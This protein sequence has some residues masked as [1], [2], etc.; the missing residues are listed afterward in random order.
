[1]SNPDLSQVLASIDERLSNVEKAISTLTTIEPALV[2]FDK[3]LVF[4]QGIVERLDPRLLSLEAVASTLSDR[5]TNETHSLRQGQDSL[6]QAQDSIRA[7]FEI[8]RQTVSTNFNT[9]QPNTNP[10]KPK[11]PT[12][13]LFSGKREDWKTFSSHLTLFFSANK[14]QYPTDHDKIQFAI[15]RLGEGS[16]FKYMQQFIPD[17]DKAEALRP[18]IITNYGSF[19]K[20]MS[21]NFGVQNAHIVAEAQLRSL[22]QKGSAMDYTNRFVELASDTDWNDSAKI[23]QYRVG[24]KDPVQDMIA[25]TPT[26]PKDFASFS[27]LAIDIDKR[28]YA[29]HMEKQHTAS[30][31]RSTS[32]TTSPTSRNST[33]FSRPAPVTAPSQTYPIAH[34]PSAP[35]AMDLSQAR[36]LTLEEKQHRKNTNACFYC[37]DATHWTSKCPA[38]KNILAS[39]TEDY[40]NNGS[41]ITFELG[42][43]SA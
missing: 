7:D 41:T 1:M 27:A 30:A 33:T 26:E 19:I 40:T 9:A 39:A 11:V 10:S 5:I 21:E 17:F 38:K 34:P 4:F 16:A 28:Q 36:H 37:G 6:R 31:G 42:K 43:D 3:H 12:P 29:R 15:S 24:L 14:A 20:I 8:L 2:F 32:S 22:K 35:M 13:A 25:L 18:G 23:S